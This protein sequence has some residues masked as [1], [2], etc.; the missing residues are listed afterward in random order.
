MS[1]LNNASYWTKKVLLFT[2]ITVAAFIVLR[3][4][5]SS[6]TSVWRKYF[7]PPPPPADEKYGTLSP[8]S[9]ENEG[10]KG[11]FEYSIE[12]SDG[13]LGKFTTV[14]RVYPIERPVETLTSLTRAKGKAQSLGFDGDPS[15]ISSNVFRWRQEGRSLDMDVQNDNFMIRTDSDILNSY[16]SLSEKNALDF[17]LSFLKKLSTPA[18][19]FTSENA[20]VKYYIPVEGGDLMETSS[21]GDAKTSIVSFRRSVL[22]VYN[23]DT[24]VVEEDD[25]RFLVSIGSSS[26]PTRDSIASDVNFYYWKINTAD[27]GI[28]PIKSVAQALEELKA[29]KANIVK[30]ISSTTKIDIGKISLEYFLNKNLQEYLQPVYVFEGEGFRAIVEAVE[31]QS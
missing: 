30:K 23:V 18:G 10:V 26:G 4:V 25:L 8:I 16:S 29:G 1:S 19:D 13:T 22:D 6:G 2:G 7:P 11:N 15:K 31:K 28:Y 21:K 9:F 3:F 5:I 17:S 14:A 27:F 12:T 24:P 20:Q